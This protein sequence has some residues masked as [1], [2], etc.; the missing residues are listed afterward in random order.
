MNPN[1]DTDTYNNKGIWIFIAT[2]SILISSLTIICL[3]LN[4][5]AGPLSPLWLTTATLIAALFLCPWRYWPGLIACSAFGLLFAYLVADVPI[6]SG[7][8][9]MCITLAEAILG[10]YL[11]RW[12][13]NEQDPL[14]GILSWL[15]VFLVGVILV[16]LLGALGVGYFSGYQ[17]GDFVQF[18]LRWFTSEALGILALT[19]VGLLCRRNALR[20]L[21][22]PKAWLELL[23]LMLLILATCYFS[24]RYFPFPL[25]LIVL[26][27]LIAAIRLPRFEA[28]CLFLLTTLVLYAV[29]ESGLI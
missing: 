4:H 17:H 27:L 19:P 8:P 2:V 1:K 28:F 11:L 18:V 6:I 10:G 15:M 7:R 21:S 3:D 5:S 24:L 25:V 23:V 29:Q 13:L 9:V 14:N 22:N 20:T 26:P 16:P 12:V